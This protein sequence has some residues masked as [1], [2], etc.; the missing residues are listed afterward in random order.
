MSQVSPSTAWS[1]MVAGNLRFVEGRPKH[2]RQNV[3]HR[4]EVALSQNP[5][6]ALFGCADSRLSAEIIFDKGLGDLFVVRNA[7][8]VISDSVVGSLEYAVEALSIPLIVVLSHDSCGAVQ[9]TLDQHKPGA[10]PL[11]PRIMAITDSIRPAVERIRLREGR[12]T[13]EGLDPSEV[14][15]EHLRDTVSALLSS[16]ELI[17]LAI[18]DGRLGLIGANYTLAEGKVTPDVIIGA[19]DTTE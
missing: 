8:Q 15:R 11:P 3:E 16:S 19:V 4:T 7:G 10:M 5:E 14:G 18:A 2:P 6:V 13:A 9:A 12:K 1:H 17:S